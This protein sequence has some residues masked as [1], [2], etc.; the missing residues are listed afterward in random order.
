MT[1]VIPSAFNFFTWAL[2][3]IALPNASRSLT[4]NAFTS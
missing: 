3:L 4:K 2:V 1:W